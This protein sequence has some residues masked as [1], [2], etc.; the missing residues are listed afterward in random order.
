M[1]LIGLLITAVC[2]SAAVVWWLLKYVA[3]HFDKEDER[4]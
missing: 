2:I 4:F 1:I 3:P